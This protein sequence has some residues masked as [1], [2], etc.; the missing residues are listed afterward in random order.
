MLESLAEKFRS[1]GQGAKQEARDFQLFLEAWYRFLILGVV[2]W[3]RH[4]EK[5]KSTVAEKL[6]EGRGRLIR[7]FLHSGMGGLALLGILLAPIVGDSFSARSVAEGL[8]PTTVLSL[9]EEPET[10]T[11]TFISDKPRG[12]ILEYKIEQGDTLSEIANRYGVS[13]ESIRWANNLEEGEVLKP[14]QVIKIPPVTGVIHRVRKGDTVYSIAK[15]YKTDAQG[16]VDYPYNTFVNDETFELAVGQILIVPDGVMPKSEKV[17]LAQK[18]PNAG[19]VVASGNFVWPTQGV[20]T[21]GFKWYHKAIDI[22]NDM[23]TLILAADS[24]KVVV[25]GWPDNVGY[26][27][28][29]V[30]DHGNGFVTLYG[31]L[32]KI[33]VSEGQTVR[34]GEVIGYMGSTGRSTGPHLHFE[35]RLNGTCQNPLSYLK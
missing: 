32:S 8:T 14:G 31:H 25:A 2:R 11:S 21:Q 10:S 27:N 16:I 13:V 30:I 12:E 35:I 22:A 19:T 34:R 28:R 3:F 9:D 7:P 17:Y 15:Y 23:G 24:G 33:A 1:F 5:G 18:T 29:V 20:I 6:Y 4:L 26:G